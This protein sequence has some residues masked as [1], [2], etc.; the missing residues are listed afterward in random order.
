MLRYGSD[1]RKKEPFHPLIQNLFCK[2]II[3]P[4]LFLRVGYNRDNFCIPACILLS[5]HSKF[6]PPIRNMNITKLEEELNTLKFRHLFKPTKIGLNSNEIAEL[7]K[8]NSN[9]I[10]SSLLKIFPALKFFKGLSIN[11]YIVRR[12][13]KEFRIFPVSLSNH[14]RESA[15]FQIDILIDSSDIRPEPSKPT[16]GSFSHGL[17]IMNLCKLLIRFTSKAAN[18]SKYE[19]FCRSCLRVFMNTKQRDSHY[20]TC[21]NQKRGNIGRRK[22]KNVLVHKPMKKNRFTGKIEPN[23]LFFKRGHAFKM[24][25]PL[26]LSFLD[27]EA[28]N[29]NVESPNIE[30]SN[31]HPKSA[32]T[33][34]TP[35]SYSYC[36]A[37]TY[38][39]IPLPPSL[40]SV[41]TK[42]LDPSN[43]STQ[44]TFFLNLLLR[45][46]KDMMAFHEHLRSVL[47]RDS[48]P[49]R[50]DSRPTW[51]KMLFSK[52]RTCGICGSFFFSKKTSLKTKKSYRVI[53]V[54]DHNHFLADSTQLRA[55]LCQG[56]NLSLCCSSY[57]TR[58]P[59]VWYVHNGA[60]YDFSFV[61]RALLTYGANEVIEYSRED[62][63]TY[64]R[65]LLKGTPKILF[66][67]ESQPICITFSFFCP[68]EKCACTLSSKKREELKA[69][70]L[71]V[72]DCGLRRRIRFL[73]SFLICPTSLSKMVDDLRI[74]A[75]T[76]QIPL[77]KV[78]SNTYRYAQSQNYTQVQFEALTSG[79]MTMPFEYVSSFQVLQDTTEPPR[80]EQFASLLR[81]VERL[82]E[83]EMEEFTR[84]W[85]LF[86]CVNLLSLYI[87]YGCCD[88]TLLADCVIFYLNKLHSIT[89]LYASQFI[90]LSSCALSSAMLNSHDPKRP[91]KPLFLPFLSQEVY[92]K[93]Q[94]CLL[95]GYSVNSCFYSH[96]NFGFNAN[97]QQVK[98]E[99]ISSGYYVDFNSL[100]PR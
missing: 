71:V 69:K 85:N 84:N 94:N 35:L 49:P 19:Y 10:P 72:P 38:P 46:R 43:G 14:C 45:I 41:R 54:F 100:Y 82:E 79:K 70:G 36:F 88:V 74:A 57:Y 93:F 81:G 63:T 6:G 9:P 44:K 40:K 33:V 4:A 68:L 48:A 39:E 27:F 87:I 61:L 5:L 64:K 75:T 76:E 66:K 28:S 98:E 22:S 18:A 97:E 29:E 86:N 50:P 13:N 11:Q 89:R 90:T 21:S 67:S 53:P 42:Y 95:G 32:K 15:Y 16:T 37:S 58:V 25:R 52:T 55:V 47:S 83:S 30:R 78:F 7:E 26:G 80:P 62:G 20:A 12:K 96:F 73:D 34:H 23:G 99:L 17:V 92:E 31:E 51:M 91:H 2:S 3:D 65:P 60:N 1:A 77:E 8:I 56:C 24:L 59:Y